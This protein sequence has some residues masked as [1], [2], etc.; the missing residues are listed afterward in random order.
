VALLKGINNN[1]INSKQTPT[2][3][4]NA[5][6]ILESQGHGGKRTSKKEENEKEAR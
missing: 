5:N 1:I 6:G 3:K 2:N 4:A